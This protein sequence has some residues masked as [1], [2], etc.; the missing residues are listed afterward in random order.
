M[1]MYAQLMIT[2]LLWAS[3]FVV[4][5]YVAPLSGPIALA[6]FRFCIAS[7]VLCIWLKLS[8][9]KIIWPNSKKMCLIVLGLGATGACLYNISF[10]T[11]LHDIPAGRAALIIGL[12][13]IIIMLITSFMMR[14][15]PSNKDFLGIIL[16]FLGVSLALTQ[17]WENFNGYVLNQGDAWMLLAGGAWCSY[18]LLI[19]IANRYFSGVM[20]TAYTVWTGTLLLFPA[21]YL[22]GKLAS[23]FF[24]GWSVWLGALHLG[25]FATV[26][27]FIWYSQ[28]I[29]QIGASRAIIFMNLIPIFTLLSDVVLFSI[30]LHW[31]LMIGALAVI[32]GVT[33]TQ[34]GNKSTKLK[35]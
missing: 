6:F 10:F 17:G 26:L 16:S 20:I 5:R 9:Q 3:A 29:K 8:H 28:G 19:R 15:I 31:S 33:L 7:V 25:A 35:A 21:A 34:L 13:P 2:S 14:S 22:E 27:A 12:N 32:S 1:R 4:G 18:T 11:A 24:A 23:S 30:R